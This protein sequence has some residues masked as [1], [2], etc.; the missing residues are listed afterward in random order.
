MVKTNFLYKFNIY[1]HCFKKLTNIC[2]SEV[3]NIAKEVLT[4]Y[5]IFTLFINL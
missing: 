2:I 4:V 1:E 3:C 5:K